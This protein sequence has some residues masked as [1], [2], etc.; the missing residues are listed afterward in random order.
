MIGETKCKLAYSIGILLLFL[1]VGF[2][3]YSRR[4]NYN[5]KAYSPTN[6][7]TYVGI[8]TYTVLHLDSNDSYSHLNDGS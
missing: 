3:Q 4:H 5:S 8:P 6:E 2:F 7:S 1:L